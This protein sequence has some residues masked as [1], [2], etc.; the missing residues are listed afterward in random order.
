MVQTAH[1]QSNRLTENTD[2]DEGRQGHT[3]QRNNKYRHHRLHGFW[4]FPGVHPFDQIAH[5]IT[6][7][8]TAQKP[9]SFSGSQQFSIHGDHGA[10]HSRSKSRPSGNGKSEES[11]KNRIHHG[12]GDV[13]YGFDPVPEI[14]KNHHAAGR[15]FAAEGQ[16]EGNEHSSYH[17]EGNHIGGPVH[18]LLQGGHL[19]SLLH[20][21]KGNVF[22]DVL[23]VFSLR[24]LH[25]HGLVFQT[26]KYFFC[27]SQ[28]RFYR[29][30][31]HLFP[32]ESLHPIYGNIRSDDHVVCFFYLSF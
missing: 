5:Q 31:Q 11:G 22:H 23:L 6:D 17:H 2:K 29:R 12:K 19:L 7:D 15:S 30:L 10:D 20:H 16:G 32:C 1:H 8:D 3:Q 25:R 27:V 4:Y 24:F 18:Q 13:A 28:H 26:G 14:R 21:R 9:C